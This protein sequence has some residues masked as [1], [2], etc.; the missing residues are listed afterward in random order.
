MKHI[1]LTTIIFA[2]L[3]TL[4]PKS[5]SAANDPIVILPGTMASWNTNVLMDETPDTQEISSEGWIFTPTIKQY[6]QLIQALRD[7]GLTEGEDFFVAFYDWRQN[8]AN[9]VSNYLIPVLNEALSHSETGKVDIVAHSMGGLVA[10]SY[11]QGNSYRNDVDQLIM[12][13][14][15][16]HGSSDVYTLWEGGLIPENWNKWQRYALNAYDWYLRLHSD[17]SEDLYDTVHQFVPSTQE[18]LPTYD[19]LVNKDTGEFIEYSALQEQ[20]FFL[21]NLNNKNPYTFASRVPGGIY[22]FAGTGVETVGD[23]TIVPHTEADGKLWVDGKPEPLTPPRNNTGGDNRVLISSAHL[24]EPPVATLEDKSWWE[25]ALELI[26]PTATAGLVFNDTT[27]ESGHGALP[28]TTIEQVFNIL[29]LGEPVG[30]YAVIPDPEEILAFWFASPVSVKVTDPNGKT[31]TKDSNTIPGAM[32]DGQEDPL[33][34]KEVVIENPIPGTYTVEL[35]GLADGSYH[36]ATA[37]FGEGPETIETVEKSI[38]MNEK[39]G[40]TVNVGSTEDPVAISDP[41]VPQNTPPPTTLSLTTELIS[42][43]ESL[44]ANG[45]LAQQP[46]AEFRAHLLSAQKSLKQVE[47]LLTS[48]HPQKERNAATLKRF[49]LI[50]LNSFTAAVD[51]RRAQLGAVLADDLKSRAQQIKDLIGDVGPLR[52][53]PVSPFM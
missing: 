46:Y 2:A 23:I 52:P 12:L 6:D 18:M 25:K 40:Y 41:F 22:T 9:S 10:R 15:P 31:I 8:N 44:K 13:G 5:A 7:E 17:S 48:N 33:G 42:Y 49:A 4:V 26:T 37:Y 50:S 43:V 34:F 45:T 27:L 20:N 21:S 36:F 47:L 11:I 30:H 32:Y 19:Y 1:L 3:L 29:G 39:V 14:T 35:T 53:P 24:S 16:N 51:R 38:A 28:T